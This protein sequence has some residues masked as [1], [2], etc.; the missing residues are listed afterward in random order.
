MR[1]F[2]T[3]ALGLTLIDLSAARVAHNTGSDLQRRNS[4]NAILNWFNRILREDVDNSIES[5]QDDNACYVDTFYNFVY[6]SSDGEDF[7]R[8]FMNYPPVT[9]VV[10]VTPTT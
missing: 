5:R 6:N 1:W 9:N 10:D 3:L 7:C 4:D 2:L 8:S